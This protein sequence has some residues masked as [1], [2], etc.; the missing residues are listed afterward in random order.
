MNDIDMEKLHFH[1]KTTSWFKESIGEPTPFQKGSWNRIKK[2]ENVVLISP[3]GSGKTMAA[4]L[5]ALDDIISGRSS[6]DL[7]SVLYISPMKAMGADLVKTLEDM[8][9]K[10]G[11]LPGK[12][13][14]KR[15]RRG[16]GELPDSPIDIGIRTG[17]VPQSERRRMLVH[18]P[19][20][21]ITTPENL[22][23]MLCSKAREI[24]KGIRY[25]IVDEVH[26]MISGKRGA[27]LS[28]A[29]EYLEEI[30]SREGNPSPVRVGLSA[31]VRP[32][33]RA[34]S[35][36]SGLSPKG[37]RRK[38]STVKEEAS[39]RVDVEIR[40]LTD[41]LEKDEGVLDRIT[42]DVGEMISKSQGSMVVFHNTRTRAEKMA[43][44]LIRNGHESVRPHHGSL[45]IDV[46][47][48]AEEGLKN[49]NLK[50][51]VSSTSLELGI[52]IGFV[53]TVC[54]IS[55]PKDPSSMMQRF[56]RSGHRLGEV[57][58][59]VIYPLDGPDLLECVAVTRAAARGN[60][61]RLKPPDGPLDVLAQF[62]IGMSLE[63]NGLHIDDIFRISARAYP[64]KDLRKFNVERTLSL[65]SKRLPGGSQ[66]P[67]RLWRDESDGLYY[68][69]RNSRQ[70][71]YLN[72]GT[73]P[74]ET[75]YRVIDESEKRKIGDL[76]RDF[77]ETLYEGDVILLGSRTY[78]IRSFSGSSIIVRED[79]EA[80]PSVPS[81][82]G[83]VKPR[84]STVSSELY[85]TYSKG[86]K[87]IRGGAGGMKLEVDEDGKFLLDELIERQD[88]AGIKPSEDR[89]PVEYIVK[90]KGRHVY[91]FHLPLGRK[92]TDPIGRVLSYGIRREIGAR[93]DYVSTDDG[94]AIA[95]PCKL[96]KELLLESLDP[97]EF[98]T[99]ARKLIL[100][101]SMFKTRF[102]H[103]LNKS[104]L[105]LARFRG[106]ETSA[107]Y[108][109]RRVESLLK[110]LNKTYLSDE[111]PQSADPVSG[112]VLLGDEAMNEVMDEKVDL[113]GSM[114][115]VSSLSDGSMVMDIVG[116]T[117]EETTM[118]S[119]IV[120]SW[121]HTRSPD[122]KSVKKDFVENQRSRL[123]GDIDESGRL[124]ASGRM[125]LET[126]IGILSGEGGS[127]VSPRSLAES[128]GRE[129]SDIEEDIRTKSSRGE[130]IG[131]DAEDGRRLI[132]LDEEADL[133]TMDLELGGLIRKRFVARSE[134]GLKS[135]LE[136]IPFFTHPLE[137]INRGGSVRLDHIR[138]SI[139]GRRI[140]PY[141]AAG[142]PRQGDPEWADVFI[143]LARDPPVI[144]EELL[145]LLKLNSPLKRP[146]I[147]E[148]TGLKGDE[149]SDLIDELER[150]NVIAKY[151]RE[152]ITDL[153]ARNSYLPISDAS[154][155]FT[156]DRSFQQIWSLERFLSSFGPFTIDELSN[157]FGWSGGKYP[158]GLIRG[159]KNGSFTAGIGPLGPMETGEEQEKSLWIWADNEDESG[160]DASGG[161]EKPK[162]IAVP[163][164]D[165]SL[166]LT[167]MTS[168]WIENEHVR[169]G[170]SNRMALHD[171]ETSD[172]VANI[173]EM[174]D[175]IRVVDLEISE[176]DDL[177]LCTVD[178]IRGI[179]GYSRLDHF[180]FIV[181]K[182]MGIPAGEAASS[183]VHQFEKLGFSVVDTSKGKMLIKGVE[184]EKEIPR[185]DMVLLMLKYQ[186]MLDGHHCSHPLQVVNR[187]TSISD[188][189]E[190]LSR[191]GSDRHRRLPGVPNRDIQ[192]RQKEQMIRL[193]NEVRGG[194]R[195]EDIDMD[196]MIS[197]VGERLSDLKDITK[198]FS[199]LR[200]RM[201][202]PSPVWSTRAY[203]NLY[204]PPTRGEIRSVS[205]SEGGVLGRIMRGDI[206]E[207]SLNTRKSEL[208]KTVK[209]LLD[210]RLIAEDPWGD[211]KP[212]F[213]DGRYGRIKSKRGRNKYPRGLL[214]RGWLLK[215]AR[216]L[217]IFNM[218]DMMS[219]TPDL[220]DRCKIRRMLGELS[221][222]P[223][224]RFLTVGA[225]INI[226]YS[227]TERDPRVEIGE[228]D[229]NARESLVIISPRDRLSKVLSHDRKRLSSRSHGFSVFKYGRPVAILSLKKGSS[230]IRNTEFGGV[231][232]T[233]RENLLV[234]RAWLDLRYKRDDLM[235]DIRKRFFDHGY[236]LL[237]EEE[238]KNVEE[239]YRDIDIR[240]QD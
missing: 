46:R 240:D 182:L 167:G 100:S 161:G 158:K 224:R 14:R 109:R 20:L 226:V 188:R 217:G 98:G 219:Y 236:S 1:P 229:G 125:D 230:R 67:P 206:A 137:L 79:K 207:S 140:V 13:I 27:L 185:E 51:I 96:E 26:E 130:V 63:G 146:D 41:K 199:L 204:P 169:G 233:H 163:N 81:W 180:A 176:F 143:Q 80:S 68:P 212:V 76:S 87:E 201:D 195:A 178:M 115:I 61:E 179:E 66:P 123:L 85:E 184:A 48:E 162:R 239:L 75:N 47:R 50:C 82:S 129:I 223:I 148:A 11:P 142:R 54:Q 228:L 102:S 174:N 28:L 235:R 25:L 21:L 172:A 150:S 138:S 211:K 227:A 12:K 69:R 197:G 210:N 183:S 2:G 127:G 58:H 39:K 135:V 65:L 73:I 205:E 31:T 55:S 38:I 77:G 157:I 60:L 5:P 120:K 71:F 213:D 177:E 24:L 7:T 149:L 37:R 34:A 194:K 147:S 216:S 108:R 113:H 151:T 231:R 139:K 198:R 132:P 36:V 59:G 136:T 97:D 106:K 19:D 190:V 44:S 45:G 78:R 154:R 22:L 141:M 89:I 4:T 126:V 171:G 175:L 164:T 166:I 99:T 72:C 160:S 91:I 144:P 57:S 128:T 153:G 95:S 6:R 88:E 221:E 131:I 70:A 16:S 155:F 10:I 104:L 74:K 203:I 90:S 156:G 111:E 214:Q 218:E 121:R 30:I 159:L 110:L 220:A 193:L 33:S 83:E 93:I 49:G 18:P 165:S 202:Q 232:D 133:P 117:D 187:L 112:L 238:K 145:E 103:C 64:Y 152:V 222:G 62:I 8:S 107:V 53:N 234:S 168:G 84:P 9:E 118:G 94:F 92:V 40:T 208:K 124:R 3:T 119:G 29:M 209:A 101:S 35:Y 86:V 192:I 196:E 105:V 42:E 116:P 56:G 52:D 43:Y 186:N 200:A 225:G 134:E 237:S 114:E 191:L 23:L 122:V 170:R 17:D 15:G 189:W 215:S 181:E 32:P 173:I